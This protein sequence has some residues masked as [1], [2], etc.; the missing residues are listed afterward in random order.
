MFESPSLRKSRY[1]LITIMFWSPYFHSDLII[2]LNFNIGH[3]NFLKYL[4]NIISILN[5]NDRAF[6][7]VRIPNSGKHHCWNHALMTSKRIPHYILTC[8]LLYVIIYRFYSC[9]FVRSGTRRSQVYN[10]RRFGKG[11]R[12]M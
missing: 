3:L 12:K 11:H 8:T 4:S 1:I 9:R 2:R 6:W 7:S 10:H 5:L